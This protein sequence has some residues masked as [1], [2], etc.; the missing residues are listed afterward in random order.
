M[1]AFTVFFCGTGSNSWDANYNK[2]F[3]SGELISTL[4]THHIGMEFVDWI[5]V[6]GPG[7]GNLQEDQKWTEPGNYSNWQGKMFGKGWQQNVEHAVAMIKGD[8]KWNR[9]KLSKEEYEKLKS[10]GIPIDDVQV[11]GWVWRNYEYPDR[12]VTPQELQAQ[13]SKIMRKG[14]LPT[15]VNLVGWSRGGVT[16]HMLANAMAQ[17]PQLKGIPVNIFAVDPVPGTG[18]FQKHRISI[19]ANVDNYVAVYARDERSKGFACII[20]TFSQA[21]KPI[22]LPMPGRHA[23]LVGNAAVDGNDGNDELFAPGKIVRDMAENCLTSWGTPLKDTLNLSQA[24]ICE[25][26]VEMVNDT[27]KYENLRSHTYTLSEDSGGERS[28]SKGDSWAKFSEISGDEY[29]H[30]EGLFPQ[31]SDLS[32]HHRENK[33]AHG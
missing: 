13:K 22:V 1:S 16:C 20:P 19:P 12:K 17:D 8:Y 32:W 27:K 25:L 9:E 14:Q 4:A 33:M 11:S 10:A 30:P 7:S 26:Y 29:E 15:V 24:N 28:V 3:H 23:T 18:Q 21:K 31:G 6:D 5:V 2:N